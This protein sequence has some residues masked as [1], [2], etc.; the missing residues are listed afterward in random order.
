MKTVLSLATTT[1]PNMAHTSTYMG[2]G[3]GISAYVRP[4]VTDFSRDANN[5]RIE[6]ALAAVVAVRCIGVNDKK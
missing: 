3:M 4:R 1:N 6:A 5:W 2:M